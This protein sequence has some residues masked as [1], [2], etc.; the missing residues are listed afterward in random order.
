MKRN[1]RI[2]WSIVLGVLPFNART[3]GNI[4]R[5]NNLFGHVGE[6]CLIQLRKLP[7]Y[8]ELI[9]LHNNICIGSNVVF[10]THDATYKVLNNIFGP[11]KFVEEIGCIEIMDNV[12]IGSGTQ[13]LNNVRIGSNVII[14][15]G[16]VVAKDIPDNTVYT[17]NPARYICDFDDFVGLK[18]DR[19]QSFKSTYGIDIIQGVDLVLANQLYDNFKIEKE[20][21]RK[22]K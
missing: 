6:N 10:V 22:T 5:K 17:G 21:K 12:F 15:A 18:A 4:I 20:R 19:T 8:S 14:G 2:F 13:I 7:L 11:N 16:S 9:Y 3:I 1:K